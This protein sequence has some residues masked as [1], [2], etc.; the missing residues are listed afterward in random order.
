MALNG[1]Y[2]LSSALGTTGAT[3]AVYIAGA[4]GMASGPGDHLLISNTSNGGLLLAA[5]SQDGTNYTPG[6][7]TVPSNRSVLIPDCN[8]NKVK[9][10]GSVNS[11]IF[12]LAAWRS[13]RKA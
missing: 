9:L 11:M 7:F 13:G 3:S 2:A 8:I 10:N 6:A 5:F 4:A 1:W 12:S